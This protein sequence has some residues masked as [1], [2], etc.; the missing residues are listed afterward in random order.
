MQMGSRSPY[1]KFIGIKCSKPSNTPSGTPLNHLAPHHCMHYEKM[2]GGRGGISLE[3]RVINIVLSSCLLPPAFFRAMLSSSSIFF[4]CLLTSCSYI[5]LVLGSWLFV[6]VSRSFCSCRFL[7]FTLLAV[8]SW[9]LDLVSCSCRWLSS[10][11]SGFFFATLFLRNVFFCFLLLS[12]GFLLWCLNPAAW[13]LLAACIP[14]FPLL[15]PLPL[16]RSFLTRS[17][18]LLAGVGG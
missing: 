1:C 17:S 2:Y 12:L 7:V 16:R 4:S 8:A 13:F 6:L 10:C 15:F 3:D 9:L 11:S 5:L 18:L 14:C